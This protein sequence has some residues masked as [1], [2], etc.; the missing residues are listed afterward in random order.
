[1]NSRI[2]SAAPWLLT[3]ALIAGMCLLYSVDRTKD[4]ELVRLRQ[5]N[6][7]LKPSSAEV[8]DPQKVQAQTDE[9][10]RL[11]KDNEELHRL[12]NEIRQLHEEKR[13]ATQQAARAAGPSVAGS[14]ELQGK[15]QQALT[16]NQQLRTEAQQFQLMQAQAE[17]NAC[18]NNLRQI[19]GAKQQWA[20]ENK[21]LASSSVPPE[22][23][24]PYLKGNLVPA[25][26][27]GGT[28]TLNIVGI[29]PTCSL[30]AA[31]GHTL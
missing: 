24:A 5:E 8:P 25:C 15:L 26:P 9:L 16:E 11:R 19:D 17:K 21:K 14:E 30:G 2:G 23:I 28:Y 1:M 20:L 7:E 18:I 3:V 22:D 29:V 13:T 12:R 4:A 31:A 10:A 27:A 6:S